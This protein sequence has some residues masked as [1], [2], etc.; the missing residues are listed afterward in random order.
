VPS[1]CLNA[2]LVKLVWVIWRILVPLF[3]FNVPA[4]QFWPMFLVA[5]LASGYWLAFNFQVRYLI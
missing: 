5:E 4:S 3:V 2:G 1:H